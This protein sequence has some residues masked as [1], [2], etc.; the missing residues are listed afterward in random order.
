MAQP[1]QQQLHM[2][3]HAEFF[4]RAFD[5]TAKRKIDE[6]KVAMA[7]QNESKKKH[8]KDLDVLRALAKE[9]AKM[10]WLEATGAA[11]TKYLTATAAARATA[12]FERLEAKAKYD[13]AVGK[14]VSM[15]KTGKALINAST[16]LP[17]VAPPAPDPYS[18]A[19]RKEARIAAK[20][21]REAV[22]RAAAVNV[23]D[24]PDE[25]AGN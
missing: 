8:R 4:A 16:N 23:D 14:A 18:P 24:N 11:E 19:V 25:P 17:T 10:D 7:H 12:D 5:G 13:T 3:L 21:A 6:A 20:K 1:L 15:I 2:P 9:E 22:L